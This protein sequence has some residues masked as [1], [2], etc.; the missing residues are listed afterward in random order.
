MCTWVMNS[1]R[2]AWPECARYA[3][4]PSA[5]QSMVS[6]GAPSRSMVA[7]GDPSSTAEALPTPWKRSDQAISAY[8]SRA[9]PSNP[10]IPLRVV[11]LAQAGEIFFHFL[12][13]AVAAPLEQRALE[14][15]QVAFAPA[16]GGGAQRAAVEVD[17][18][19]STQERSVGK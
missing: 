15:R 9:C 12:D 1:A 16:G 11:A 3:V 4:S 2:G 17:H 5:P 6:H 10:A 13:A 18:P 14:P 19:A 7:I 8:P